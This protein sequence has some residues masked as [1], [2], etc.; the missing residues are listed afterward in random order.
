M[1]LA[2]PAF[3]TMSVMSMD[4]KRFIWPLLTPAWVLLYLIPLP[5]P[6]KA[7]VAMGAPRWIR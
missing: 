1:L 3:V 6:L 7:A 5:E 2:P 4:A